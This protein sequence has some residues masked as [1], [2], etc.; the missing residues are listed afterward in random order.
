MRNARM[1]LSSICVLSSSSVA[2]EQI[3]II[4]D[5]LNRDET[6]IIDYNP[7]TERGYFNFDGC[8]KIKSIDVEATNIRLNCSLGGWE[9]GQKIYHDIN[10]Y[11]GS[12]KTT[13]IT[14]TGNTIIEQ[15]K[16]EP[17]GERKF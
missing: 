16:C 14:L 8:D 9:N 3:K 4:C 12:I 15:G 2:A 11:T 6:L 13:W 7:A 5:Y 17:L 10:R 1:I